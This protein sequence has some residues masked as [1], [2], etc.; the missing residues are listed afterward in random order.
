MGNRIKVT[1]TVRTYPESTD[2]ASNKDEVVTVQSHWLYSNR[3][4]ITFR[5]QEMVVIGRDI[6]QAIQNCMNCD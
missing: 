6:I 4:H 5:N 2:S 1:A 3:V